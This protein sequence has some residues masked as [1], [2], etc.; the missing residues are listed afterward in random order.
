[1]CPSTSFVLGELLEPLEED[2]GQRKSRDRVVER[3]L[4]DGREDGSKRGTAGCCRTEEGRPGR[5][6]DLL[7]GKSRHF[8]G[9]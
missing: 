9:K 2:R 1:M 5:K 6:K 3:G 7:D 4:S 8:K